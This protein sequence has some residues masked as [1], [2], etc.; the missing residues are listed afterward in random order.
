MFRMLG[1]LVKFVTLISTLAMAF[2]Q[3]K[4]IWR[5]MKEKDNRNNA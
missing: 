5:E 3:I 4:Q 2:K 1:N